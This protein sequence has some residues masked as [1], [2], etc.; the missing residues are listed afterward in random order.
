M[1]IW[2]IAVILLLAGVLTFILEVVIPPIKT[3]LKKPKKLTEAQIAQLNDL[4]NE[5][6]AVLEEK[7]QKLDTHN[8]N[9]LF[10]SFV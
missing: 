8:L 2:S 10:I 6:T 5:A 4:R 7:M 1:I 3:Y 9:F